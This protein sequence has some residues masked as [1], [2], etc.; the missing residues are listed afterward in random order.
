MT[1]EKKTAAYE[2]CFLGLAVGDA[3]GYVVDEMT[4][5]QITAAYGPNGLL[6]YDLQEDFA[7]VSSYTQIA[8]Y[9]ANGLLLGMTRG[10]P[11]DRLKYLGLALREWI[12]R[13]HFPRSEERS[14]CW[15]SQV[16][17]L[18]RRQSSDL[19]RA[20]SRCVPYR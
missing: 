10:K 20:Y 4:W 9:Y 8:A 5:N 6:G 1:V 12:H 19:H 3:L 11:A 17:E 14:W 13:Q 18:R 7:Q 15:V 2:G 16:P